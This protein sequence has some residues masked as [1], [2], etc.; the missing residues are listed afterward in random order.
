MAPPIPGPSEGLNAAVA[1]QLRAERAANEMTIEQ[2]AKRAGVSEISV[3]RY[4]KAQR[5]ID[6]GVLEALTAAMGTTTSAV[7]EAAQ[8]RLVRLAKFDAE[9]EAGQDWIVPEARIRPR[10]DADLDDDSE[11]AD[12]LARKRAKRNQSDVPDMVTDEDLI[13]QPSVA[14]PIPQNDV[15]GDEDPEEV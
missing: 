2:V 11:A 9:E 3:R 10:L 15:E 13:G 14:A 7:I 6:L 8:E 12:E 1:A 5:H 4:L